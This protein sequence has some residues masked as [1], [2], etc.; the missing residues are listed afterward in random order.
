MATSSEQPE[1]PN[2]ASATSS[3]CDE[4]IDVR[5]VNCLDASMSCDLNNVSRSLQVAQLAAIISVRFCA[6]V[7]HLTPVGFDGRTMEGHET[8]STFYGSAADGG[9]A[10]VQ[11]GAQ[12][13]YV[14][15]H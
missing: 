10:F 2:A 14:A 3:P 1:E 7:K 9:D 13:R 4:G 15:E 8:L 11:I 5:I 6:P 12:L